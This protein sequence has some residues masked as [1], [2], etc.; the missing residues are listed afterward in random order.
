MTSIITFLIVISFLIF[1][2]ELGHLVAAKWA[3]VKV[4]AFSIGF[5]KKLITFK[6]GE[7]EYSLSMLPLGGYVKMHGEESLSDDSNPN[8]HPPIEEDRSYK[9]LPNYKKQIILFAG[10]LMNLLIP[11]IFFPII[12]LSGIEMPKFLDEVP[13]VGYYENKSENSFFQENDL[14]LKI[15]GR[16]VETW[17]S[18]LENKNSFVNNK[19]EI[20]L[21]RDFEIQK[22]DLPKDSNGN[23]I[24]DRVYP[25]QEPV[26]DQIIG[27]SKAEEAGLMKDDIIKEINGTK[28]YNW[29]QIS[30]ILN[31]NNVTLF[32]IKVKRG[33]NL[34]SKEV[35]FL[36]DN[37]RKLLGIS[38]LINLKV[39]KLGILASIT[40]GF[41]DS[42]RATKLIF[43]GI[44]GLLSGLFS[45]DSSMGDIKN[46]LAGPIAIAK[47]S[48]AAAEKGL[49]SLLQFMIVISINLGIINLL[50]IPLLDGGHI[51]FNSI[52]MITRRKINQKILN[53]ANRIGF[54]ALITLMLFAIYNDFVNLV[55]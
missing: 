3:N 55:K 30:K 51:F 4:E 25:V 11:F 7:T 27:G 37:S 10:P 28:I 17:K 48:G 42:V 36:P 1:I 24:L 5:G 35:V 43:N 15:N 20:I 50:P 34:V 13:V 31:E 16:D 41:N 29:Y 32:S 22:F 6:Y 46:S 40:T 39:E 21:V 49:N 12:H 18:L 2:H 44:M 52:E 38:P 47:Y 14:I 33:N 45:S 9:N 8:E 19:Q 26:I 53:F 54:A 23:S